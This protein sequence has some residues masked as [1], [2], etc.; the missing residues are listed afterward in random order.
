MIRIIGACSPRRVRPLVVERSL[1][2]ELL[3]SVVLFSLLLMLLVL[4]MHHL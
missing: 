4:Q 2:S 1:F 3:F